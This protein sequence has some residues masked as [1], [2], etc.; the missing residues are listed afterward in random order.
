MTSRWRGTRIFLVS[1]LVIAGL[2]FGKYELST[3]PSAPSHAMDWVAAHVP[4]P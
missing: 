2:A 1:L 4:S 3:D